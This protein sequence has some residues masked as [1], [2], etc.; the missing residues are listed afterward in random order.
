MCFPVNFAKFSRTP[1]L[2]NICDRLLLP[3]HPVSRV[4]EKIRS[5]EV[6][7]INSHVYHSYIFIY[8]AMLMRQESQR[9]THGTS[10]D[11]KQMNAL[12]T[13][14]KI[15]LKPD[16]PHVILVF[17]AQKQGFLFHLPHEFCFFYSVRNKYILHGGSFSLTQLIFS[18][19]V[20]VLQN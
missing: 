1:I 11:M 18:T 14:S 6:S 12:I 2:K 4:H 17:L 16:H 15:Q 8:Q 7:K 9:Q 10:T 19:Y 3:L 5:I 20:R 13:I